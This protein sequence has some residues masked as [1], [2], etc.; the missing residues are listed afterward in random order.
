MT[1]AAAGPLAVTLSLAAGSVF[2]HPSLLILPL[3]VLLWLHKMPRFRDDRDKKA[4]LKLVS[5]NM[6]LGNKRAP[7]A[8]SMLVG[9]NP[10]VL[11]LVEAPPD[12]VSCLPKEGTLQ[13]S[14][15]TEC[16]LMDVAVW[17]PHD[18]SLEGFVAA[19]SRRF[20][21]YRVQTPT[22][23]WLVSPMHLTA[24][25]IPSRRRFWTEQLSSLSVSLPRCSPDVAAG[26]FN[27]S[28]CN[29]EFRRMCLTTRMLPAGGMLSRVRPSWGPRGLIPLLRLDHVL[30]RPGVDS[31]RLR[32]LRVPGSDHRAVSV[33]LSRIPHSAEARTPR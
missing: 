20:P 19:G 21:V 23:R 31:R 10:D 28:W 11:L 9:L 14:S 3:A 12:V 16:G 29:P 2:I 26:D 22:S 8:V 13:Y 4:T 1:A 24:P 33:V 6:L 18:V 17:S 32:L 25:N 30:T 7:E 15:Q 5:A 27:A